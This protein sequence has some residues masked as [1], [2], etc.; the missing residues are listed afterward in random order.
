MWMDK[1]YSDLSLIT[2]RIILITSSNYAFNRFHILWLNFEF[3]KI[4]KIIDVRNINKNV[5]FI[6]YNAKQLKNDFGNVKKDYR[7][8]SIFERILSVKIIN[9]ANKV[10]FSD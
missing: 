2:I 9:I 5:K 8:V 10:L 6:F 3:P 7:G 4:K 1:K